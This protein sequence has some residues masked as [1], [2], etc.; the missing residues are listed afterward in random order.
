ME[1]FSVVA[2]RAEHPLVPQLMGYLFSPRAALTMSN[3]TKRDRPDAEVG[4]A[5]PPTPIWHKII[6]MLSK[7]IHKRYF[8]KNVQFFSL[9]FGGKWPVE[10]NFVFSCS[11]LFLP[12]SFFLF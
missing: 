8:L 4:N 7:K 2:S 6:L 1:T 11:S 9:F 12:P 5:I 10:C 3:S